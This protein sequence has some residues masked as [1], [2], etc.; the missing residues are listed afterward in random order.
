M[1]ELAQRI[2]INLV[3]LYVEATD[4]QAA[5]EVGA[6]L[7]AD[8]GA[9][10]GRLPFVHY[11]LA[12][13][14]QAR[15]DREQMLHHYR[16]AAGLAEELGAPPALQVQINQQFAWQLLLL[17]RIAEADGHIERAGALVDSDDAEGQREQI[18][19][20]CLRAYQTG[21][22]ENAVALAE[23]FT[24]GTPG[25]AKHRTWAAL[26]AGWVALDWEQ[27]DQAEALA[28]LVLQGALEQNWP[29]MMNRGNLLRHRVRDKRESAGE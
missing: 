18:L 27:L 20:A 2:R 29:E 24:P 11:N 17:D 13:A 15:R 16:T 8:P 23:E 5:V 4:Y 21:A 19:L 7:L 10:G 25:T 9:L 3:G 22:L 12:R 28:E 6:H 14:H 26:I 1:P